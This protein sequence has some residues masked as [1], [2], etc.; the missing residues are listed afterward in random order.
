M[1]T[2]LRL[3]N[4]PGQDRLP[5]P[6][7]GGPGPVHAAAAGNAIANLQARAGNRAVVQL[8]RPVVQASFDD[9]PAPEPDAAPSAEAS[10]IGPDTGMAA[11]DEARAGLAAGAPPAGPSWTKV[12]PPTNASY[13]VSGTLRE[14]ANAVA[15]RPEAG[16]V[17]A[18]PSSDTETWTPPEGTEQVRAARVTVE[19]V[20][21][22]PSWTD[23][24]KATKNQQAEWDRFHRAISTHEAGHVST[25]T[26]SFAGAHAAM[27]GKTPTLADAALDAVT[28]KAK[29]DNDAYDTANDHGRKQGTGIN[30]NIDEVTKV[31]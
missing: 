25:D 1:R 26:T 6:V 13:S 4:E 9:E 20:L 14:V 22:L 29:T 31:P 21:E 5:G 28:A 7:R 11:I 8:L 30:P 24:T 16:S 17:T 23:R 2:R 3:D 15:A 27:V 12:G 18:T 19:Q 10:M